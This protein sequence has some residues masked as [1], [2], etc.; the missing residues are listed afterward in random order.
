MKR[1][2]IR[3]II[4]AILI[5]SALV[6][7]LIPSQQVDAE[8]ASTTDFQLNGSILVKYTGTASTVSVPDTVKIIGEE[9]F[10]DNGVISKIVLPD[11][12]EKISYAAFSGCN[13]LSEIEIP[14]SVDTI[15]TA[16]FCNCSSLSKVKIGK[17]LKKLGSGVFTGCV[18]LGEVSFA[19][20]RFIVSKG[21]IFDKEQTKLYQYLPGEKAASY[22]MP[23]TVEYILPYSFYGCSNLNAVTLSSNLKE[24]SPFSFSNCNGLLDIYIPYSVNTI[25]MKAFENCVNLTTV[26]IP[27]SVYSIHDS[28]FDGCPRLTVDAPEFSYAYKWYEAMDRSQVSIIDSEENNHT[29]EESNEPDNSES[30]PEI[31]QP[32]DTPADFQDV[33]DS[34]VSAEGLIGETIVVGRQAVVFIDNNS[35][36]VIDGKDIEPIDNNSEVADFHEIIDTLK[37]ETNGKGLSLPKFAIVNSAIANKAY[38]GDDKLN[39]YEFEENI[40]TIGDFSFARTGLK[41]IEIPEGV[42]DIGYGAFYHCE[43]LSTVLIPSTVTNIE[44]SAFDKTRMMENFMEYGSG[45]FFICGDGILLAYRGKDSKIT[46]PEGVKQIGPGVFKDHKGITEVSLPDSLWRICEDAFSGCNNLKKL[47]GG[48]NVTTIEDRAFFGCPLDC[49]RIVDSLER[50]GL[51]AFSYSNTVASMDNRAVVFFGEKLPVV[52]YCDTTTRLSNENYRIDS[53]E[54]VLVAVV[55]SESV[56]RSNTV[57]DRNV[58]GF[59]GLICTISE[60]NDSYSNGKLNIIDCTLTKEEASSFKVPSTMIIFGK[61]YNFDEN[62]LSNV[63]EMASRGEFVDSDTESDDSNNVN[64]ANN[65]ISALTAKFPGSDKEYE[66]LVT[67]DSNVDETLVEGYKRIYSDNPPSNLSTYSINVKEKS[68]EVFLTKF[69]KQKLNVSILLPSNVPTSNLHV[70]CLDEDNQLEDIPYKLVNNSDKLY[71][72]IDITHT[73][74]YGIYAIYS[75][76]TNFA[77]LDDTPDTGDG[78]NP[79]TVLSAGLLFLGLAII[80]F[81]GKSS[82]V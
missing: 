43:D 54:G 74:K 55:N 67:R 53:L 59:S 2:V 61:G 5:I 26:T 6:V 13:N 57:L 81:K 64:E 44:P 65:G 27:E 56:N 3:K 36:K 10:I 15:E 17:G 66:L 79:K 69:G 14:D 4:G 70:I 1:R 46:I 72:N 7:Y 60:E 23:N 37:V 58:S 47:S 45:D 30:T 73:G 19:N 21:A 31:L 41:S 75:A 28:A 77:N 51:G 9:A 76:N 63:I 32:E 34:Y 62:Q 52:S 8:T 11:T 78:V 18:N 42:T 38:Y 22:S 49:I 33:I 12:I 29:E 39:S 25:D 48:T 80:L 20:D 82:I 35:Q 24:V 68:N 16:A 71:V 40:T 50:I